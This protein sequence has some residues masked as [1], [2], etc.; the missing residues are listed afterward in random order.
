M[1]PEIA[2]LILTHNSQKILGS[3]LD[4]VLASTIK[5][6]IVV[7]DNNST[8]TTRDIVR[9]RYPMVELVENKKNYNFGKAYNRVM[10]HRPEPYLLVMNDD[11]ILEPDAIEKSYKLMKKDKKAGGVIFLEFIMDEPMKFPYDRDYMV[12][13]RFNVDLGSH[14]HFESRKDG[15]R[16]VIFLWGGCSLIRTDLVK[17]VGFDE[18]F[19]WYFEDIDLGWSIHNRFGTYFLVCPDCIAHHMSGATTRKLM[20][21]WAGDR[22]NH[23]NSMLSFAK[24][25]TGWQLLRAAPEMFYQLLLQKDRIALLR[26]M[27]HKRKFERNLPE[28]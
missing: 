8:D 28:S 25:A 22:K 13:K 16:K 6:N 12:K 19:S 17:K 3:A 18:D 10:L 4:S 11:I 20:T 9:K 1:D 27:R 15:P 21:N 14:V 24:N 5:T 26:Q 23:R 2:V 7:I